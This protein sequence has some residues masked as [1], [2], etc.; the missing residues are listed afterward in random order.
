MVFRFCGNLAI[1]YLWCCFKIKLQ[2]PQASLL[3]QVL[4]GYT[5]TLTSLECQIIN[6]CLWFIRA[7][8][9]YF[10]VH[11][12]S[13]QESTLW[14]A[15]QWFQRVSVLLKCNLGKSVSNRSVQWLLYMHKPSQAYLY[16]QF[17]MSY[18]S[19]HWH[20]IN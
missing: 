12:L 7:G 19:A 15:I 11:T 13:F 17:K 9:S 10:N 20:Y 6:F 1:K 3:S 8:P 4:A 2:G 14:W 5:L 18:I 16:V